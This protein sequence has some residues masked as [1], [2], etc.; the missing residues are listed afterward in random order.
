MAVSH[1]SG[2]ILHHWNDPPTNTF[3]K[4]KSAMSSNTS[5]A[6]GIPTPPATPSMESND[7]VVAGLN[8]LLS[9]PS[10]LNGRNKEM[11]FTRIRGLIKSIEE[12]MVPG[13]SVSNVCLQDSQC[14]ALEEIM[15]QLD[16]GDK[17]SA[18][19]RVVKLMGEERGIAAWATALRM[20]IENTN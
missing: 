9:A 2:V 19:D 11:I 12:K 5:L 15:Q 16:K 4:N 3:T 20:V 18:R 13:K 10:K 7:V 1:Q 6:A 14:V 17:A 8:R